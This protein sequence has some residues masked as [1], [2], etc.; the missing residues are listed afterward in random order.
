MLVPYTAFVYIYII[1][2]TKTL[3]NEKDPLPSLSHCPKIKPSLVYFCHPFKKKFLIWQ[4]LSSKIVSCVIKMS[5][6]VGK[7]AAG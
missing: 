2:L 4:F 3:R 7:L 1:F 5:K 6:R